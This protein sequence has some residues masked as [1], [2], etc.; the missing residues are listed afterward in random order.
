MNKT[1]RLIVPDWQAGNNP[2]Y[3]LGSN[4]L[5]YLIPKNPNQK[6]ITVPIAAPD[7]KNSLL[8]KI[9]GITAQ[10]T[11]KKNV[12]LT[13]KAIEKEQPDKI[14]TL[15]G[16]CLVSQAPFDYLHQKYGD[17]VGII[18]FDAHPD[19]STP[20]IF[21]NEHAM[22]LGNLM[23][24]GDPKISELVQA[25]FSSKSILYVALQKTTKDE[26]KILSDLDLDYQ[27]ENN[28]EVNFNKIQTW[29]NK[30]HFTKLLIHF[31]IDVLDPK[32][33][34]EQYFDNPNIIN[35]DVS[36]GNLTPDKAIE[37]LQQ[38]SNKNDVIGLTIAEYL[39]WSALKLQELMNK[40]NIFK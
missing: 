21:P 11:V 7:D 22:V 12:E 39:P 20:E 31:D 2:L 16:N 25:P 1:L 14:I 37:I 15:G 38:I 28:E 33:F 24:K 35:Y 18:W 30:N 23:G 9:N 19:I 17:E 5:K 4:L 26:G 6:E 40:I 10:T 36:N 29:I 3:Y 34:H 13:I 8:K 32:L 27:F